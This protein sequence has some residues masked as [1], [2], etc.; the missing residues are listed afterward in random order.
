VQVYQ[1][2]DHIIVPVIHDVHVKKKNLKSCSLGS[3]QQAAGKLTRVMRIWMLA[4]AV[5][6]PVV[7]SPPPLSSGAVRAAPVEMKERQNVEMKERQNVKMMNLEPR[8][9]PLLLLL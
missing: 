2:A 6:K 4:N 9:N 3:F 8:M 1:Y 7:T 5:T